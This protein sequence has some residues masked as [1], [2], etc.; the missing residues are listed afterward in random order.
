MGHQRN[1]QQTK[2]GEG[3]DTLSNHQDDGFE[4]LVR[5]EGYGPDDDS[6]V[7]EYD[8]FDLGIL[9][10]DVEEAIAAYNAIC[11]AKK[12]ASPKPTVKAEPEV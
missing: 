11:K 5:W 9:P 10:G 2:K 6:W 1:T 4:Y 8:C 7:S 12:K 3:L